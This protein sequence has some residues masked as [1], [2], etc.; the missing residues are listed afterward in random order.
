MEAP[1]AVTAVETKLSL[2]FEILAH[3][4]QYHIKPVCR[5]KAGEE[6]A[7]GVAFE[8]SKCCPLQ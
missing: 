5:E 7:V 2:L 4:K 1:V 8:I 6:P 3:K